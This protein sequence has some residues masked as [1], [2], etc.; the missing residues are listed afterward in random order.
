M[1]DLTLTLHSIVR[2]VVLIAGVIAVVQGLRGWRGGRPW[3]AGDDRIGMIYTISLDIQVLVG[4]LLFFVLSPITR[5]AMSSMGAAMQNEVTRFFL[6]E[7]FPIMLIAVIVAH[8][9]RSRAR[10][11]ADETSKH[12]LSFIFYAIS[13]VLILLAIPWPFMSYGRPLM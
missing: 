12:R 5:A 10:K 1:Y 8:I 11:A 4:L 3:T 2:W 7:H 9:G 6:V 13:L